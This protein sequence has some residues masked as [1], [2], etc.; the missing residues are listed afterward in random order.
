MAPH[1]VTD[2]SLRWNRPR[3]ATR[4]LLEAAIRFEIYQHDI[5]HRDESDRGS[6][7]QMELNRILLWSE[8]Y[9]SA[10]NSSVNDAL[11]IERPRWTT[12]GRS[13]TGA[14]AGANIGRDSEY[15]LSWPTVGH[16]KANN[17]PPSPTHAIGTTWPFDYE[18]A[19]P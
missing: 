5:P 12:V 8:K 1:Q 9:D 11:C 17:L 14:I 4:V 16:S 7:L 13:R 2:W 6:D 10:T 3:Q 18:K 15:H 19:Q